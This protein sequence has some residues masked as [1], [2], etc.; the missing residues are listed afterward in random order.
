MPA[1]EA[2]HPYFCPPLCKILLFRPLWGKVLWHL[3]YNCA[4]RLFHDTS[5]WRKG[6]WKNQA[7]K[8]SNCALLL[9]APPTG[10][11]VNT[12]NKAQSN[13]YQVRTKLAFYSGA[14]RGLV[15][16]TT[17]SEI[18]SQENCHAGEM[19]PKPGSLKLG[20]S[21]FLLKSAF[22]WLARPCSRFRGS[23]GWW[24]RFP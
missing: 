3:E 4:K 10:R 13:H 18:I 9:R 12:A 6:K 22:R 11:L 21:F 19:C 5:L 8:K 14:P 2:T 16:S 20:I 1:T 7:V 15:P 24:T 17:S 23:T